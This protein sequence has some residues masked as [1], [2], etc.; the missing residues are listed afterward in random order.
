MRF[1][2]ELGKDLEAEEN[3]GK[4]VDKVTGGEVTVEQ[5]VLEAMAVVGG[6]NMV[7]RLLVGLNV[8]GK[9]EWTTPVPEI[10]WVKVSGDA[11]DGSGPNHLHALKIPGANNGGESAKDKKTIIFVNSL[12]TNY[13]MWLPLLSASTLTKTH[14]LILYDQRGHG[15]ST[16]PSDKCTM[17]QLAD[18]IISVLDHFGVHTAEAVV[19]VSQ[20]GA[21]TL[22]FAIRHP[23]RANKIVACDTQPSTPAANIKAWDERIE[24]ARTPGKGMKS[25]AEATVP[26]WFAPG[27]DL[28]TKDEADLMAQVERTEIEGFAAG[29]A[30][31]QSYDLIAAGLIPALAARPAGSVMLLA[32]E[33]DGKLPEGLVKLGR[34]VDE[35]G[36]GRVRVEVVKGGGHL[37]MV[38]KAVEFGRVLGE[39]LG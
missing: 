29:A 11:A 22:N 20:G 17:D 24:L 26:R 12:M 3:R 19:G 2:E 7:S 33:L 31:L 28:S 34:E 9:N 13:R 6:Y 5:Q 23:D 14:D 25:L 10:G 36:E 4:R 37:P 35:A 1:K 39:F 18:D 16:I 38:N 27:S 8:D 21:T 32:G 15:A 30:A